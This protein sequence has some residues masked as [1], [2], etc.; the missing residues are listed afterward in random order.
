MYEDVVLL[1]DLRSDSGVGLSR[2]TRG[3]VVDV[4]GPGEYILEICLADVGL[5]GGHRVETCLARA[6][7]LVPMVQHTPYRVHRDPAQ[8][9]YP[10][11]DVK[12]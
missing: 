3:H 9:L 4:P 10:L 2:G 5:V 8:R 7:D 1:G 6:R 12:A 11:E